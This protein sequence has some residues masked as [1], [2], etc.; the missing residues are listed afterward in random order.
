MFSKPVE[1][2]GAFNDTLHIIMF[3]FY[4]GIKRERE[5]SIDNFIPSHR[6]ASPPVLLRNAVESY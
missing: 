6:W 1:T 4:F 2:I 3:F 5:N